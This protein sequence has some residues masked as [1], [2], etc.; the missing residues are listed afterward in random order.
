MKL[1]IFCS[2]DISEWSTQ[3]PGQSKRNPA[4]LQQGSSGGGHGQHNFSPHHSHPS[5]SPSS[6]HSHLSPSPSGYHGHLSHS[7]S[8]YHSHPFPGP[9]MYHDHLSPNPSTYH[10]HPPPSSSMHHSHPSPG[11]STPHGQS[12]YPKSP[13]SYQGN[14]SNPL[15]GVQSGSLSHPLLP[16]HNPRDSLA[17]PSEIVDEI[18]TAES[19]PSAESTT[20]VLRRISSRKDIRLKKASTFTTD[21]VKAFRKALPSLINRMSGPTQDAV[22][23][24][25]ARGSLTNVDKIW[26]EVLFF[27][28]GK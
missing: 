10:N 4:M 11:P 17:T 2:L 15:N 7:P 16:G 12:S 1:S 26:D 20:T 8:M 19:T 25:I 27:T 13:G 24:N 14:P 5:P 6:Y 3:P 22:K 28:L 18:T 9:S 21:V 23:L